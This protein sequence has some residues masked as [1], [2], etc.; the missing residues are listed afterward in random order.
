MKTLF[1]FPKLSVRRLATIGILLALNYLVGRFSIT[2]IPK[3]LVISFTFIFES[4]I[5]SITGPLLGFLTLGLFDIIDT[6]FSE[7]AGMFL[8]GW[9]IMEAIMGFLYGAFFYGKSFTWSSKKDWLYVSLAMT[10]ITILGSFIMTP[11]L[12]QHYYHVP[13]V[14]QF[15]A[16]RWI[17]IFEIP[18]R[19]LVTM[20][21]LPQL[22]RIP[23]YR[24]LLNPKN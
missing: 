5:G 24:K 7:K 13:I 6:L 10:V 23:E 21:I 20:A 8:I 1:T 12:I 19:I 18:I 22:T 4:I 15:V 17:K 9:T 11:W 14:A 3:Q 16:G 2:I